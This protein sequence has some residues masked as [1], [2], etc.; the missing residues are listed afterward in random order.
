MKRFVAVGAV[1]LLTACAT[2]IEEPKFRKP[3][4]EA[5]A[6]NRVALAAEYLKTGDNEKAQLQLRRALD[7]NPDSPE[8]H[9]LMGVLLERDGDIKGADRE[10]RKAIRLREG[11]AQA[12]NN[13]GSFLFRQQRY[14][15]AI[16]QFTLAT[17]DMGYP[18][19]AQAYEGW[20]RSAFRLG[21][22]EA[23]MH[24]ATRALKLDSSLPIATLLLAE[25]HYN[26]KNYEASHGLYKRYLQFTSE[27]PQTAQSL[28]LGIRLERRFGNKDAL[29]SYELAL[30]RLYPDS[31]E[32][33]Q[34]QEALRAEK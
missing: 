29:A 31:P 7:S 8:A 32:Y 10:Y 27:V 19:R 14:K 22:D 3:D 23:A 13:Y 33:K 20:A 6:R 12:H 11:Y 30:K 28:W 18:L 9:N 25:I 15:D 34:Y 26:Q 1:L 21:N 16:K 5:A 17:E 2:V 24:A 4:P